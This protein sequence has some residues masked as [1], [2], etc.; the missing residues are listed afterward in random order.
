M[1]IGHV[2]RRAIIFSVVLRGGDVKK[3]KNRHDARETGI[4]LKL[5]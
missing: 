4:S 5:K 2:V 1:D 3:K